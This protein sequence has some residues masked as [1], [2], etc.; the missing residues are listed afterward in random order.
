MEKAEASERLDREHLS[1]IKEHERKYADLEAKMREDSMLS[2]IRD[3]EN[4]QHVAE[5][6][7]K[8]S[9]LEMK[10]GLLRSCSR[11]IFQVFLLNTYHYT[12]INSRT[13][14]C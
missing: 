10:V 5:L 12:F 1:K 2:R 14:L 4:S 6:S 3:A 7:Q 9:Q 13:K 8:I 11:K